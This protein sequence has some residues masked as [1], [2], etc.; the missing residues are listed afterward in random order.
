MVTYLV[1]AA[2]RALMRRVCISVL[3]SLL[4]ARK[5]LIYYVHVQHTPYALRFILHYKE[6]CKMY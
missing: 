2:H 3:P 4:M 6:G 5:A 1:N